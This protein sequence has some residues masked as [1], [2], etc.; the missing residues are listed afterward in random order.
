MGRSLRHSS[1]FAR[2]RCM[3]AHSGQQLLR[4]ARPVTHALLTHAK[5]VGEHINAAPE[6]NM[7]CETLQQAMSAAENAKAATRLARHRLSHSDKSLKTWLSNARLVV[8]LARGPRWSEAWINT[9]FVDRQTAVPKKTEGRVELARAAVAFFARHPQYGVPFAEVTAV[10]G[11]AIYDRVVQSRQML[12]LAQED[13]NKARQERRKAEVALRNLLRQVL[14]AIAA[15]LP[16][17]HSARLD[18]GLTIR[19]PRKG[20]LGRSPLQL[21]LPIRFPAHSGPAHG[22]VAAA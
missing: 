1:C 10:R 11:R 5:A 17:Y 20:G 18:F 21:G 8:M 19:R 13:L 3:R 2:L 16:E 15:T 9:G 7:R 22:R 12:E 6:L 14:G 4:H